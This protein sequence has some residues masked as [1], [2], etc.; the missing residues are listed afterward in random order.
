MTAYGMTA[1]VTHNDAAAVWRQAFA[2]YDYSTWGIP[3]MYVVFSGAEAI[4]T[5]NVM[6]HDG[7]TWE[8]GSFLYSLVLR[9]STWLINNETL[10]SASACSDFAVKAL[11]EGLSSSL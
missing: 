7:T 2:R 4:A 3:S 1:W 9:G 8:Y 10:L 6:M 11:V 5:C